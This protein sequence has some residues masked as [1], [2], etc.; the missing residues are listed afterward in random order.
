M[1]QGLHFGA[2]PAQLLHH[3]THFFHD[4]LQHFAYL[5][6]KGLILL[7]QLAHILF[8]ADDVQHA[9]RHN[10]PGGF[11]RGQFNAVVSVLLD[12]GID[13]LLQVISFLALQRIYHEVLQFLGSVLVPR[14]NEVIAFMGCCPGQQSAFRIQRK[15]NYVASLGQFAVGVAA[16]QRIKYMHTQAQFLGPAVNQLKLLF[17]DR[18]NL[19]GHPGIAYAGILARFL[20]GAE[21]VR[22]RPGSIGFGL[23]FLCRN[24]GR[25]ARLPCR[26]PGALAQF[27]H[28]GGGNHIRFRFAFQRRLKCLVKAAGKSLGISRRGVL[29]IFF[30]IPGFHSRLGCGIAKLG[31]AMNNDGFVI[32]KPGILYGYP[33]SV[34]AYHGHFAVSINLQAL[35]IFGGFF[36]CGFALQF[37]CKRLLGCV[38][39]L[40]LLLRFLLF[41][42]D[43]IR[44]QQFMHHFNAVVGFGKRLVFAFAQF[45]PGNHLRKPN[46]HFGGIRRFALFLQ[47]LHRMHGEILRHRATHFLGQFF[48][49]LPE[50]L[51][52]FLGLCGFGVKFQRHLP[53]IAAF[54]HAGG[55]VLQVVLSFVGN[56]AGA[57]VFIALLCIIG[58]S[59]I[60]R[61]A[62]ANALHKAAHGRF[63]QLPSQFGSHFFHCFRFGQAHGSIIQ[64]VLIRLALFAHDGNIQHDVSQFCEEF[65]AGVGDGVDAQILEPF[66]CFIQVCYLGCFQEFAQRNFFEDQFECT[67]SGTHQQRFR[68][69]PATGMHIL[70]GAL[71][72]TGG[73][74]RST[75]PRA[76]HAGYHAVQRTHAGTVNKIEYVPVLAVDGKSPVNRIHYALTGGICKDAKAG[77]AIIVYRLVT[78][79]QF[80]PG[81]V[82]IIYTAHKACKY[83]YGT[84]PRRIP[85]VLL[86]VRIDIFRIIRIRSRIQIIHQIVID[87][88]IGC[89][90]AGFL[91]NL[92]VPA[93]FVRFHLTQ[94]IKR[95]GAYAIRLHEER[96]RSFSGTFCI[97]HIQ[98]HFVRDARVEGS[99][100]SVGVVFFPV[101]NK[102]QVILGRLLILGAHS[103]IQPFLS[104]F[105]GSAH[106]LF[107]V[108]L[109]GSGCVGLVDFT[110]GLIFFRLFSAIG[111]H[112]GQLRISQ[113]FA[114]HNGIGVFRPF[115][116]TQIFLRRLLHILR[117]RFIAALLHS[118]HIL[119]QVRIEIGIIAYLPG[120]LAGPFHQRVLVMPVFQRRILCTPLAIHSSFIQ[121]A[122][123]I[124]FNA[125]LLI[126]GQILPAINIANDVPPFIRSGEVQVS[127]AH[128]RIKRR[129]AIGHGCLGV[130]GQVLPE[131]CFLVHR[132]HIALHRHIQ[133]T[134]PVRIRYARFRQEVVLVKDALQAGVIR[135]AL[136]AVLVR[137]LSHLIVVTIQ[138]RAKGILRTKF[139]GFANGIPIIRYRLKSIAQGISTTGRICLSYSILEKIVQHAYTEWACYGCLGLLIVFIKLL[140]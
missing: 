139:V 50:K 31:C 102:I 114:V 56:D 115:H 78:V 74:Q 44:A 83:A 138:G 26:F 122:C 129:N 48:D 30:R 32:L 5:R 81:H 113:P 127:V 39:R 57:G 70:H 90:H 140:L 13:F 7:E 11:L 52:G 68:I 45:L 25:F 41:L 93:Y 85:S 137:F 1:L 132:G 49:D 108:L 80:L 130:G 95:V 40:V 9:V 125:L 99:I 126:G 96:I 128:I 61:K 89:I 76:C 87:I 135:D 123:R 103:F 55:K 134:L 112:T 15:G 136:R 42:L 131:C 12:L 120:I 14:F 104:A 67:G 23:L 100:S 88:G 37:R 21:S 86:G 4:A 107:Q 119:A 92:V 43:F 59:H 24:S 17:C 62:H 72:R 97:V 73:K 117:Q 109:I 106:L 19:L 20:C 27:A 69:A 79:K 53:G 8:R 111:I 133:R 116:A 58:A 105:R 64:I 16:V 65:F 91:S 10:F 3:G 36:L 2:L 84:H 101:F 29:G 18:R 82:Q 66:L 63:S 94:R 98:I 33:L 54:R 110:C 118:L 77:S 60:S 124:G 6:R 22:F 51:P 38:N 28:S 35:F 34:I 47:A 75:A 46:G 121:L 71:G